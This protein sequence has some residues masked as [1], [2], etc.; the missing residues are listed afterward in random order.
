MWIGL[1][2]LDKGTRVQSEVVLLYVQPT[3]KF[4]TPVFFYLREAG[5]AWV[6]CIV[7]IRYV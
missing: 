2:S 6:G 5:T 3:V 7:R 1:A 4:G